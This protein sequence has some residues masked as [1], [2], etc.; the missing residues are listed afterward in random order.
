LMSPFQKLL[1][2]RS[3]S[4]DIEYTEKNPKRIAL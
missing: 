4:S 3:L 2:Q 1:S